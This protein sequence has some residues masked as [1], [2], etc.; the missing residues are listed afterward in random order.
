LLTCLKDLCSTIKLWIGSSK[1]LHQS[2]A[3]EKRFR[4]DA[5]VRLQE[6]QSKIQNRLDKLY[7]DRLDGFIE[8]DFFERKAREWRQTQRR[9]ADQ[10]TEY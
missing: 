6:E 3:D 9:L 1:A 4:E 2:H 10:I 5:I 7:D 8:P